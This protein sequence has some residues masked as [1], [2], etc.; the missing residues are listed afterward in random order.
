MIEADER[1]L[2]ESI[3]EFGDTMVREVM[4]PRPDMVT[5]DA[6]FRV[7]D[8]MEV[9]LLNGYSRLPVRGEG[10]DDVIGLVYAKDLMRAERDGLEHERV[11]TLLRTPHLVP[12]TK[13]VPELLREMQHEKFHMAIVVDEYGGTAGLV[14]LEDLIEELVGEI[15]DEFD[16]EDPLIE[17]QAGG[18]LR[19][20]ARMALDE[21]NDLLHARPARGRLGLDRRA[22][23][24]RAGPGALRGRVGRGGRLAADGPAGAGAPDRAG[25]GRPDRGGASG[26]SRGATSERAP[27]SES[28]VAS[29]E[30]EDASPSPAVGGSGQLEALGHDMTAVA[31][32]RPRRPRGRSRQRRRDDRGRWA[33]SRCC[34]SACWC[35]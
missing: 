32:G 10:I 23:L 21:V 9:V 20:H 4:V 8:V 5:V 6:S 11:A 7:A 12:E 28:D 22:P 17:P 16:V 13:R 2:I 33:G 24:P 15:V 1:Q 29:P 3:I 25:A 30:R 27:R 35:S 26:S 18:G 14:T 19:A 31:V 34:P